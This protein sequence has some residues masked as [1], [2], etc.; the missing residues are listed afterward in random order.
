MTIMT[1]PF[2]L[3]AKTTPMQR[4]ALFIKL[5]AFIK[6]YF[7]SLERVV[8][9][10]AF[11][12]GFLLTFHVNQGAYLFI[13]SMGCLS[14]LYYIHGFYQEEQWKAFKLDLF[15]FRSSGIGISITVLALL[16]TVLH[17]QGADV[18]QISGVLVTGIS[19]IAVLVRQ[20]KN[21]ALQQHYRAALLRLCIYGSIGMI[22]LIVQ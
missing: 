22:L 7:T 15:I 19:L 4:A 14:F 13:P 2:K 5:A 6:P 11:I 17:Y 9:L 20:N 3:Y 18:M 10:N 1:T 16:F 8:S 21:S 12:S